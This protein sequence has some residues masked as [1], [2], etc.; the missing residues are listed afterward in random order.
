[1]KN[2]DIVQFEKKLKK[3]LIEVHPKF[4]FRRLL[5]KTELIT[6][7]FNIEKIIKTYVGEILE[8]N[9]I[10]IIAESVLAITQGRAIPV[11]Q[12]N[13]GILARL[14]WRFV[15]KNPK[16]IGLRS[17]TSMQCAIDE[18]GSIKIIAASF[19]GGL[20]KIFNKSG[21]FYRIAGVQAATIDAAYTSPVKPYD[22]CV[23]KGPLNP[24][25]V[26]E[27]IS[28]IY[29]ID[30]AIMDINDIGGSWVLG[31]NRKVDREMLSVIM[32]DNPMG[33]G[34]QMTPLCILRKIK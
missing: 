11:D 5:I 27:I 8:K 10:L 3:N 23:V 24:D 19:I 14:L 30:V 25:G 9:D 12:I 13:P 18:T 17:A 28:K 1:M 7:R 31:A 34:K 29:D 4:G 32:L 26:S 2:K 20:S 16:G 22:K 15:T 33:Q 21:F 6:D